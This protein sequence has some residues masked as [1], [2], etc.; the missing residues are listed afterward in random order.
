MSATG[1]CR[2]R[3]KSSREPF[4]WG[5][6]KVERPAVWIYRPPAFSI[7]NRGESFGKL[8]INDGGQVVNKIRVRVETAARLALHLA[9]FVQ[10]DDGRQLR[11]FAAELFES[12]LIRVARQYD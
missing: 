7:A 1:L 3:E 9:L 4:A 2:G 11:A 6:G 8:A 10:H 12:R 5:L